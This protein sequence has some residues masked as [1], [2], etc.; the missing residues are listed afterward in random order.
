MESPSK[1]GVLLVCFADGDFI[2]SIINLNNGKRFFAHQVYYK[3]GKLI[4]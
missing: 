4:R 2:F 1:S 3:W